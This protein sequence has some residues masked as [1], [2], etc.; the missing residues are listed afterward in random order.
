MCTHV[1][2]VVTYA[3]LAQSIRTAKIGLIYFILYEI[4]W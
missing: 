1:I 4:L 2:T 3:P